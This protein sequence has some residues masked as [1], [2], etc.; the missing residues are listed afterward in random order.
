MIHLTI[1]DLVR[2][3]QKDVST[4]ILTRQLPNV[5]I[6]SKTCQVVLEQLNRQTGE[7]RFSI[8]GAL[9]NPSHW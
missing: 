4:S 7:Y 2:M 5:L 8:R 9:E 1:H 6:S 3:Q